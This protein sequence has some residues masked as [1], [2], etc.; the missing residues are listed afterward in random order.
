MPNDHCFPSRTK[1]KAAQ[2]GPAMLGSWLVSGAVLAAWMLA[3]LLP[4][5][6]SLHVQAPR[7]ESAFIISN[8]GVQSAKG[9][10]LISGKPRERREGEVGTKSTVVSSGEWKIPI[11]CDAA[12]SRLVKFGNFTARCVT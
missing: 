3:V 5:G 8:L 2:V 7:P 6:S 10:R 4:V 12:F 9:D 11:G 1:T